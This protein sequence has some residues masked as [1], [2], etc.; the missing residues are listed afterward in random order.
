MYQVNNSSILDTLDILKYKTGFKRLGAAL[1]DCIAFVPFVIVQQFLFSYTGNS[2]VIFSC[3]SF[4]IFLPFVYSVYFHTKFGQ[5]IGKR[6]VGVKVLDIEET[7]QI[8]FYQAIL[9]D[10][11]YLIVIVV[12]LS[13]TLFL[14]TQTDKPNFVIDAYVDFVNY[15]I[16]LWPILE[17]VTMMTNYKR[18]SIND[19]LAK[20][21][22]VRL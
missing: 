9:R 2:V 1:I 12:E 15:P 3:I 10:S 22:V 18:R 11:I 5:T 8:T 16:Y 14:T 17:L 20:T 4:A 13:Y 19:F 21:V 7:K 6:L